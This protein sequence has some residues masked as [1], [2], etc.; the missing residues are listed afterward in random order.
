MNTIFIAFALCLGL[1]SCASRADQSE[2]KATI[3]SVDS[4][5]PSDVVMAYFRSMEKEDSV[6]IIN[7]LASKSKTQLLPLIAKAGGFKMVFDQMKGIHYD[8]KVLKIDTVS[9]DLAKVYVNQNLDNGSTMHMKFDSLYYTVY[10]E[11]G[12][13]KLTALNSKKD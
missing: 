12:V 6:T 11:D 3:V 2:Q 10:K 1:T 7:S 5:S 9:S 8:V 13:W 4:S